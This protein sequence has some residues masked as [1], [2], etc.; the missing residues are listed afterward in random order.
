MTALLLALVLL[1]DEGLDQPEQKPKPAKLVRTP[2]GSC[3]KKRLD[4]LKQAVATTERAQLTA[5]VSQGF[6]EACEGKLPKLVSDALLVMHKTEVADHGNDMALALHDQPD[7][8]KL[9]CPKWEEVYPPVAHAAPGDKLRAIYQGCDLGKLKLLT[10]EEFAN[11]ADL[12]AALVM[13]PLYAW[14]TQHGMAPAAAKGWLRALLAVPV[15][16]RKR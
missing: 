5:V 9:G 14:L 7:F 15:G 2:E 1:A 4:E 6:A 8:A 13:A 10:E 12:G 11:T 3:D 16:R